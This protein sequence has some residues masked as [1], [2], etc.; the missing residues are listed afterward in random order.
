MKISNKNNIYKKGE[1]EYVVFK[2]FKNSVNLSKGEYL[3]Y[4]S[5]WELGKMFD[6]EQLCYY[7]PT[8]RGV[9]YKKVNGKIKEDIIVKQS[10]IN[11][12]QSLILK[13][14]LSTTQLTFN[15]I[16]NGNEI[17][18]Y[19]ENKKELFIKG[20]IGVLDGMHRVKSCYKAY[21][22]ALILNDEELINNVKNTIF[23]ILITHH[24]D[25]KAKV[26]FSQM[27]K[28]LKISKS[29]AE[30]F[31]STK[32]S[33]R[34]IIKLNEHS[35]LKGMIDVRKTSINKNDEKHIVTFNTLK[36]A[37]DESFPSIRTE[38][39][40]QE[41]YMFLSSFFEELFNIFPEMNNFEERVLSKEE[42]LTCENI[43]FHGYIKIAE[44]LYMRR[45]RGT[46]IH[47]MKA[48]ERIDFSKDNN[49]WNC[50]IKPSKNGYTILNNKSN[51]NMMCRVLK[52][53]FYNNQ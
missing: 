26:I 22:S 2:T 47:E 51:R 29:L 12:M 53:E 48:L 19:N 35:V 10:N 42:Y 3:T 45:K 20:T 25:E 50:I 36:T 38:E 5:A 43:M 39:E 49:I 4:L 13:G 41:I 15:I 1:K 30:S 40:E 23:P 52:Q 34:I 14:Q 18:N 37:L 44:E 28:G 24:N 16:N 11:E 21:K 27:S 46:W 6:E 17:I 8:Q 32:S 31:D 33:N 7:T 9:K